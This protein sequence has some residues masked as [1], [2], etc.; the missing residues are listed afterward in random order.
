VRDAVARDIEG[1]DRDDGTVVLG[2]Q[3]GLA[4]DAGEQDWEP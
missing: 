3:A 2:D 1:E 4:V